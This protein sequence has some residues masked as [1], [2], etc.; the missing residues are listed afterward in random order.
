MSEQTLEKQKDKTVTKPAIDFSADAGKGMEHADR[1][2][3]AIPFVIILQGLSPQLETIDGAKPGMFFNTITNKLSKELLVIPCAFQRRFIAW[4]PRDDGGGYKGE[5]SPIDVELGKLNVLK[6]E[7]GRLTLADTGYEL[8]DTRNH[9]VLV[10]DEDQAIWQPALISLG[11][12]QI[13]KSKRW[14]SRISSIELKKGAKSYNPPSYSHI[15]HCSPVK[16]ENAQGSWWGWTINLKEVVTDIELY[17]KAK[18]FNEA[19]NKGEIEVATP[20]ST[21]EAATSQPGDKF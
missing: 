19:V 1:Q 4:A 13:K 17:N 2:S 20:P 8:K 3:F 6:D 16:E 12:T 18:T 11:S 7:D 21:D 10:Y 9:Y 5:Y 15:Y 14:M